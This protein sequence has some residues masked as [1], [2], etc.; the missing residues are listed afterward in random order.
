M[1]KGLVFA[2]VFSLSVFAQGSAVFGAGYL[3]PAPVSAAPGQIITFFVT[4]LGISSA[5]HAPAGALPTSLGGVTATLHQGSDRPAP[6]VDIRPVSTCPI[7]E[8]AV[9]TTLTA[10]TLQIPYELVPLCPLCARPTLP[11]AELFVSANGQNAAPI[12]LNALADQTHILTA[13]DLMLVPALKCH[14]KPK[15]NALQSKIEEQV[16]SAE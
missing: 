11:P 14:G 3:A 10:V 13:C 4:G 8:Q 5:V 9:C 6:I 16:H 1:L 7:P 12:Q 15:R 2:L